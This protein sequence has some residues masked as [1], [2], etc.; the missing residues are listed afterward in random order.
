MPDP[1]KNYFSIVP[2]ILFC[3]IQTACQQPRVGEI[4]G[5]VQ[6]D[7]RS[8]SEGV[9]IALPGTQ[10]RAITD[11][12]GF[13]TVNG[14]APG[15]YTVV[16]TEEGYKEYRAGVKIQAG[17]PFS[18]GAVLLEKIPKSVGKISGFVTL[19]GQKIHEGIIVLLVGTMH[20]TSTGITGHYQIENVPPGS[21]KLL[22][23][24]DG[25]L[26]SSVDAVEVKSGEE[27]QVND[28]QLRAVEV[29][30]TPT[31]PPL[32]LGTF[33]VRG[34]AFLEGEM[35]HSGIRVALEDLPAK[36]T[37]TSATGLFELTE[38]DEKPHT[39]VFSYSGY[40]EETIPN[41]VPVSATSTQMVGFITLSKEIRAES[42][43]ILQGYVYL[44]GL[45]N[46]ANTTVRLLGISQ[47]VVTDPVGRYLFVGIPAGEFILEAEHTGYEKGHIPSVKVTPDQA[48]QAPDLTLKPAENQEDQGNGILQGTVLLEGESDHGG[49]MVALEGTSLSAVTGPDGAFTLNA[50]PMGAYTV[51]FSKGGFKNFYLPGLSI[52]ASQTRVLEPVTLERDVKPPYVVDS[53][54]RDG[55]QRVPIDGFVDVVVRFSERM[56]GDSVKRAVIVNPPVNFDAFF[57][58][59]SE[60]SNIDVLHLRLYPGG[61]NPIR[62]RT[63]YSVE[64][65]PDAVTPQGIHLAGPFL[66]SFSTDGPLIVRTVPVSGDPRVPLRINEPIVIETNSPIDPVSFER[67]I[68]FRPKPDAIP[69]FQ[70]N[71]V[72]AGSRVLIYTSLR[73]GTRYRIQIENSVRTQDG[74]RFANT[75]YSINFTTVENVS[76]SPNTS[77]ERPSRFRRQ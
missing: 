51:I 39:L 61:G 26:P 43:G 75:P 2:A 47:M 3:F 25:W 9:Q 36:F 60:L 68:R 11:K 67:A 49:V 29:P 38:L 52:L 15:D 35:N 55:T 32:S 48:S 42:M 71:Y 70:Y 31:P 20:N 18:I 8:D 45:T 57:D 24:R 37:L 21:Y 5:T 56:A 72:G 19:E 50:V 53:F 22:L 69:I 63:R 73:P 10:Y 30:A 77:Y 40:L 16:A 28:V 27:T 59:E 6:L 13:F 7:G 66:F 1:N 62:F 41:A 34:A 14:L 64:I 74:Q 44:Q 17:S 33:A 65:T 12:N 23:F 76:I 54:P 4:T 58:R 46:H